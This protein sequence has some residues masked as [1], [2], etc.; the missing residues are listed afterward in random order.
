[1]ATFNY[2]Y[3]DKGL[4]YKDA[5]YILDKY[6]LSRLPSE[7]KDESIEK[8]YRV[9]EI[10]RDYLND[11]KMKLKGTARLKFNEKEGFE[12]ASPIKGKRAQPKTKIL[13]FYI[14]TT[15]FNF[16]TDL[17]YSLVRFLN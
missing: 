13:V 9:L 14:S 5:K 17:N 6:G 12:I 15:L 2:N 16:S 7:Y 3:F 11:I 4:V 8:I 1:M 10:V